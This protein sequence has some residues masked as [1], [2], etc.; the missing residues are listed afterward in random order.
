MVWNPMSKKVSWWCFILYMAIFGSFCGLE[1]DTFVEDLPFFQASTFLLLF[2]V[3]FVL[4]LPPL[5]YALLVSIP[6]LWNKRAV[7]N[8]ILILNSIYFHFAILF[9]LYKSARDMDFDFYF[10]WYNLTVALSVLWKLFA[11]WLFVLAISVAFFAF[12]Q[13][14]A[15]APIVSMLR[16]RPGKAWAIFAGIVVASGLCQLITIHSVRGSTAGFFYA[17]FLSDR[18]LRTDYRQLYDAHITALRS[19]ALD[20]A[21]RGDASVLGDIVIFV[22]QESLNSLL[23]S[24]RITPEILRAS[25]DGI[26]LNPMYG[27]SIQ[28]ERGYECILCG[29]PP[30]IAGDLVQDYSPEELRN[31]SCLPRIFKALGYHPVVFYSGN[32]N[33]RVMRL[34]ES[35]GFEKILAGD[36]MRPGDVMYDW[37]YREDIFFTRVDE[38]LQQHKTN[39]KLFIFITASA[40]NHTPFKVHDNRLL[41]KIPFPHPK[42][43]EE[44]FSN[45]IFAQDAYF[46][47]LY[48]IFTKHY[49][50]RS[51]LIALGDHA[52][53]IERHKRNIFNERGANE[54]NF[55]TAMLFVPPSSR[56]RDY[57]V[58][59]TVTQRFSQMDILPTILDMIGVKQDRWLGESFAPWLLAAREGKRTAP[60]KTKISVQPYGGGFISAIQYPQ[61]YLFDVL[62]R[63]VKVYDLQKDPEELSPVIHDIEADI[64]I[65]RNFFQPQNRGVFCVFPDFPN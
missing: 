59:S 43:F 47:H 32:R 57:A 39:E 15:F 56:R 8:L 20:A 60:A 19:K 46:G 11:P 63:N 53:P 55:L 50:Q 2:N 24:P 48:D 31:L 9:L 64:H 37:G 36:I 41:N 23:I 7:R 28:S 52:W 18:R 26:L 25:R 14:H 10:F 54:E 34:F 5:I 38:Y 45:T 40:T 30:S 61:K 62:G 12:Y 17:S 4:L 13:K 29:V 65:I 33:P 21:D 1:V 3:L 51:T 35:I 16:K 42:K 22:Q 49:A 44:H 6:S 27:N 58:G